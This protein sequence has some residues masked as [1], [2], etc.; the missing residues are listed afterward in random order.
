[1]NSPK[2]SALRF[3]LTRVLGSVANVKTLRE[4]VRHGGELSAPSLCVSTGLSTRAVQ[5]SLRALEEMGV[6]RSLGSGRTRLYRRRRSHPL[7]QVLVELFREE[8]NRFASIVGKVREAAEAC[9]PQLMAA[10]IYGS[11]ARRQDRPDSDLDIALVASPEAVASVE[12]LVRE[13]LLPAEEELVFHASVVT[14]G[15]KDVIQLSSQSD[16]FWTNLRSDAMTILGDSPDLLL[17]RLVRANDKAM[18]T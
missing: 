18:A 1:M 13:A 16:P 9:R 14:L 4:L 3:P 5:L 12:R 15:T 2:Q 17:T 8:E 6:I 11:V 7:S 10:W